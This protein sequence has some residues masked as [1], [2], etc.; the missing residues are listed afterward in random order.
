MNPKGTGAKKRRDFIQVTVCKRPPA[1][2]KS[3]LHG[4]KGEAPFI[5]TF[6]NHSPHCDPFRVNEVSNLQSSDWPKSCRSGW[7]V[8]MGMR[9]HF[10]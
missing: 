4:D 2:N 8:E 9:I 1:E 7:L 3:V 6:P 5:Q 10:A